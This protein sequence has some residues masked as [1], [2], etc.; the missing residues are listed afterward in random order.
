MKLHKLNCPNC[1]GV[2]NMKVDNR[3]FVFCPYCGQKFFMDDEKKEYTYNYNVNINK[4][5]RTI[6]DAD[7]IRAT[8]EAREK[9]NGWIFPLGMF[10]GLFIIIGVVFLFGELSAK[11]E[12]TRLQKLVTEIM[13]DIE[14]EQYDLAEVKANQL[15][16][17]NDW[18]SEPEEKWDATRETIL[19]KIK[20]TQGVENS[21]DEPEENKRKIFDWF[22]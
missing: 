4:T 19:E 9:R 8:T 2:L 18:T 3:D 17:N 15:Y 5:H 20:G 22:K 1:N 13:I 7:V 10:V 11:R 21:I 12:E 16:W 14:N 6:D